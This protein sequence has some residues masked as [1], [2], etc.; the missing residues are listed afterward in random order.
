MELANWALA[1]LCIS[2]W[3]VEYRQNPMRQSANTL[4]PKL[5]RRYPGLGAGNN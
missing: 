3:M 1:H 5:H 4:I 2:K